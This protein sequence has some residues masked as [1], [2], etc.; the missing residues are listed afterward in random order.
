MRDNHQYIYF[1]VKK[2]TMQCVYTILHLYEKVG[3]HIYSNICIKKH[4]KDPEATKKV[5]LLKVRKRQAKVDR[6]KNKQE[7]DLH[8]TAACILM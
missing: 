1:S 4:K 5:W 6:T 2:G 8:Y 3:N 7:L